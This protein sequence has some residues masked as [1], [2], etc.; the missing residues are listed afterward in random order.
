[1]VL[2]SMFWILGPMYCAGLSWAIL[3]NFSCQLEIDGCKPQYNYGW[4]LV[5]GICALTNFVMMLARYGIPESPHWFYKNGR[6]HEAIDV[7]KQVARYNSTP[8]PDDLN[9][10]DPPEPEPVNF[11]RTLKERKML[12]TL[13]VLLGIWICVLCGYN[14]FNSFLP[15]F[16]ERKGIVETSSV[17]RNMFIYLVMGLPGSI[18]GSFLVDTWL[19]RRWTLLV[20]AIGSTAGMFFFVILKSELEIVIFLGAF[21]FMTQIVWAA[22]ATYTPEYFPTNIRGTAVGT[23]SGVAR[24][25]SLFAPALTGYLMEAYSDEV[26]MYLSLGLTLTIGLF[27]LGLV[28]DTKGRDLD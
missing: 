17:Y 6:K 21:Q 4:R 25:F 16:M 20:S 26:A 23:C 13:I 22:M 27:T 9:L 28:E 18:L 8:F 3:P 5:L 1:M 7:L 19:G 14:G 24:C 15:L 10:E 2:L 11:F 12:G